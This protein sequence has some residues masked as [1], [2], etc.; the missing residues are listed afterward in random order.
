MLCWTP[1]YNNGKSV[2]LISVT[3]SFTAQAAVRQ[4]GALKFENAFLS[5]LKRAHCPF[6]HALIHKQQIDHDRPDRQTCLDGMAVWVEMRLFLF[7]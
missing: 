5:S 7:A 3:L 2:F 6:T 1:T 4:K